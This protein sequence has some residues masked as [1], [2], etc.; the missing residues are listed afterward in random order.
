MKYAIIGSR[1]FN[2][3]D[4][5]DNI[6]I[7]NFRKLN[8]FDHV[9]TIVI[10]GGAKGTDTLAEQFADHYGFKKEIYPA[11]WDQHGRSAGYIRNKLIIEAADEVIAFWDKVSKGTKH[12]IKLAF[13]LS[14]PTHIF[15]V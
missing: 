10:S 12:S 11:D 8:V 13:E 4:E 9:D 15:Y 7:S 2:N 5:L 1:S 6:L 14:K 3:Y